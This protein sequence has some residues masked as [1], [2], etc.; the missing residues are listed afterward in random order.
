MTEPVP[1]TPTPRQSSWGYT[2]AFIALLVAVAAGVYFYERSRNPEPPPV[3]ELKGLKEYFIR[4]SAQQKLADGYADTNPKDLVAD[5]PQDPTKWVKVGNE[6]TFT[7]VGTDDPAKA[8][9]EWKALITALEKTTG[10]KVKYLD[11]VETIEEQLAAVREGRLHVT[12]FNTG[13]V[14]MAVNTAGFVPLFCPADKDGKF[15]YEMLILVRSD[16]PEKTPADLRGKKIGFV[17]LS[18]NSGAKAPLLV[19]KEEFNLS[20]GRDYKFGFTG[21][22]TRSVK[23]LVADKYDAVCVASDLLARAEAT[24]EADKSKYRVIYTSKPFPPL[25]FGVPHNLPPELQTKVKATFTAFKFDPST[26]AGKRFLTQG[27]TGFAPVNYEKDW[28]FVRKIDDTLTRLFD[29]E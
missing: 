22:H 18:S 21:D 6:L 9:E 27:K 4:L 14:P 23:E 7:V 16:A 26:P 24:G 10:K 13:A 11:S 5:T 12:A 29:R 15:S 8:A 28:E 1:P 20:P 25:C 17:A 19:L 2:L 3:D